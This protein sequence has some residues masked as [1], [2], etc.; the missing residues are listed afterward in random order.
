MSKAAATESQ[1]LIPK[2]NESGDDVEVGKDSGTTLS[3]KTVLE[4]AI[5]ILGLAVPIF[6]TSFSWV[7]VSDNGYY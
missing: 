6:I 7:G 5:D 2:K 1:P 4:D 3:G